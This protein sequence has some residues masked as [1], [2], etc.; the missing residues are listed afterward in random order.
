[1]VLNKVP[2]HWLVAWSDSQSCVSPANTSAS[3]SSFLSSCALGCHSAQ[4]QGA[5]CTSLELSPCIILSSLVFYLTHSICLSLPEPQ[6][7]SP[8]LNRTPASEWIP[9]LHRGS[10]INA[11]QR[12]RATVEL[13][14]STSLSQTPRS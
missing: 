8:N 1:M 4:P 10:E 7:L 6:S 11:W 5:P 13:I 2:P 9:S 14:S 3:S 12:A